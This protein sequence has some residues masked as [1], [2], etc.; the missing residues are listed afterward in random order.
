MAI[1]NGLNIRYY[2]PGI[3]GGMQLMIIPK[4][5]IFA[6]ASLAVVVLAVLTTS[7]AVKITSKKSIPLLISGAQR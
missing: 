2:P 6:A 7:A 4:F 1:I 3:A 5:A